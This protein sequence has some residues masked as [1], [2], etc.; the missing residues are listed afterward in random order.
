[1]DIEKNY[2]QTTLMDLFAY[3]NIADLALFLSGGN[4]TRMTIETLPLDKKYFSAGAGGLLEYSLDAELSAQLNGLGNSEN[5]DVQDILNTVG[6][7]GT[8]P[9]PEGEGW[10]TTAW[11]QEVEQRREQLP[12]GNQNKEKSLFYPPHPN[13]IMPDSPVRHPA[14]ECKSAPGGFVPQG[15]GA[16]TLK[17]TALQD[18]LRAAFGYLLF[19]ISDQKEVPYYAALNEHHIVALRHDF[20][21]IDSITDLLLESRSQFLNPEVIYP[22]DSFLKTGANPGSSE[23]LSVYSNAVGGDFDNAD[24]HWHTDTNNGRV[25]IAFRFSPRMDREEMKLLPGLYVAILEEIIKAA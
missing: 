22:V 6:I 8:K 24:L 9:S 20:E 25:N 21:A 16:R 17:S 4:S 14:G 1:W 18:I 13:L 19:E 11:M 12:R 5:R 3:P 15:E 10:V 7:S 23:V 2:P